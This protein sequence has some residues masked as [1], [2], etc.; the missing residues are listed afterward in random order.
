M[1]SDQARYDQALYEWWVVRQALMVDDDEC[2]NCGRDFEGCECSAAEGGIG[3]DSF[4][5]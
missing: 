5:D 2:P 3:H 1:D 4:E